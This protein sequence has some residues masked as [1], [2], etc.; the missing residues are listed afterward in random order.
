MTID[1]FRSGFLIVFAGALLPIAYLAGTPFVIMVTTLLLVCGFVL[2]WQP[3]ALAG[4]MLGALSLCA[5]GGSGAYMLTQFGVSE[6]VFLVGAGVATSATAAF[7]LTH[8]W[9]RLGFARFNEVVHMYTIF[10]RRSIRGP[11]RFWL[12]PS[13][14][15]RITAR[16]SLVA[17]KT[18]LTMTEIATSAVTL[19]REVGGV[20]G[21]AHHGT[22]PD[23][24]HTITLSVF[25][26]LDP[27]KWDLLQRIPF[28]A[29]YQAEFAAKHGQRHAHRED[30]SFWNG[31]M[32]AWV[33]E[34]TDEY[35][36][37]LVHEQGWSPYYLA[38]Q[39]LDVAHELQ[40]VL[41]SV[42]QE[43][44]ILIKQIEII[45]VHVD[46]PAALRE[47]RNTALR[48]RGRAEEAELMGDVILELQEAFLR[49]VQRS[50]QSAGLSNSDIADIVRS[51]AR[52][53]VGHMHQYG[54]L[55]HFLSEYV[56]RRD[57]R[58]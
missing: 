43:Y 8:Q 14:L 19:E 55:D 34:E 22:R 57:R 30:H 39:R 12:L 18:T 56:R 5:A 53:L 45:D 32:E 28:F 27:E 42:A 49:R 26:C 36:R 31:L 40:A 51:Q 50:L 48:A 37:M 33:R 2:A 13:I 38:A 21:K 24:V 9:N 54:H 20:L 44:G 25:F 23:K 17:Q 41:A 16:L 52:E 35:L 10:G 46:A 1:R 15:G 11:T 3:Q 29:A 47:A 6:P 58:D 4:W 7:W